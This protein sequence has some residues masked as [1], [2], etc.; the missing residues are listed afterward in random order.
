MVQ[1]MAQGSWNFSLA[2]YH[3]ENFSSGTNTAGYTVYDPTGGNWES[4]SPDASPTNSNDYLVLNAAGEFDDLDNG[5]KIQ[6]YLVRYHDT[7][8]NFNANVETFAAN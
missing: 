3:G 2:Q 7:V 4:A 8:N 6:H 1:T 5:H